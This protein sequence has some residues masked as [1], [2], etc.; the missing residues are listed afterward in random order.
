MVH[1]NILYFRK[2]NVKSAFDRRKITRNDVYSDEQNYYYPSIFHAPKTNLT[3]KYQKNQQMINDVL[4]SFNVD[5]V[6]DIFAGSG[7]TALAAYENGIKNAVMIEKNKEAFEIMK[8][9][10]KL[11]INHN[12]LEI[13]DTTLTNIVSHKDNSQLDKQ[14]HIYTAEYLSIIGETLYGNQWQSNLARDLGLS[15]A[16]RVRQWIAGE[17]TIPSGVWADIV[18]LVRVKQTNLSSI[19]SKMTI[20]K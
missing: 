19:L 12:D 8:A 4:G 1:S 11:V 15:D 2:K 10:C 17:R 6:L 20:N 7:T 13:I 9:H 5:S 16:R 3:Y 18:E 14:E